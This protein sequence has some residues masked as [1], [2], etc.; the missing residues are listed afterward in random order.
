MEE[1]FTWIQKPGLYHVVTC[2]VMEHTEQQRA[3]INDD[4]ECWISTGVSHVLHV[5]CLDLWGSSGWFGTQLQ[6]LQP[7]SSPVWSRPLLIHWWSP[8]FTLSI[9]LYWLRG[10]VVWGWAQRWPAVHKVNLSAVTQWTAHST[11]HMKGCRGKHNQTETLVLHVWLCYRQIDP[12]H[13]PSA[14]LLAWRSSI[15][16]VGDFIPLPS[17][18]LI[19]G[20]K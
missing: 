10:P 1:F 4:D 13:S 16:P 3:D 20:R 2:L 5:H 12:F 17:R 14:P 11:A 15:M 6:R 8:S 7:P 9:A 18:S 19:K